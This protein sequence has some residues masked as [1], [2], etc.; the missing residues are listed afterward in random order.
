MSILKKIGIGLTAV[1]IVIQF[2]RPARN[3]GSSSLSPDI[4]KMVSIP[5]SVQAILKN[6][7]YDCHSNNTNYPWYSNI[8]PVGWLLAKHIRQGKAA[9]NFSEFGSYSSRRQIN[10]LTEIA[11][12]VRDGIMPISSYKFMHGDARLSDAERSLIINWVQLS[13]DSLESRN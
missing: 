4:S 5:D 9:L 13:K 10:K 11:N 1:F 12:S 3:T 2:I 6:A 7:C 8:E